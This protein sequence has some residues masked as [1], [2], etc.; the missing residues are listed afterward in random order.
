M[1]CQGWIGR[2]AVVA[3]CLLLA[4]SCG[5]SDEAT[6]SDPLVQAIAEDILADP[7]A[8]FLSQASA[9]CFAV[10][11]VSTIGVERLNEATNCTQAE[12]LTCALL[13]P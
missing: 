11:I 3:A 7:N 1:I 4:G 5:S 10:E 12:S 9:D 13:E 6:T 8:P 2:L